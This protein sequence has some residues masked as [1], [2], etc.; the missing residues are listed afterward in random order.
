MTRVAFLCC[1]L[2]GTGHLVRTLALARATA[3]AGSQVLV[4]GGDLGQRRAHPLPPARR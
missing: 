2:S 1:H 4:I 3:L